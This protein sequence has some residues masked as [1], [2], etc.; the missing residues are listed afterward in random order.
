MKD[1]IEEAFRVAILTETSSYELY[2]NATVMIPD[3]RGKQVF[4]RLAREESKLIDEILKHCPD[5]L[6]E[7]RQKPDD[8]PLPRFDECLLE[9]P[10]RR[11]FNHLRVALRH[12]H[13]CIDRY[14]TFVNA[15]RDP[16]L[17]EVFE[18][19]L[20]MSRKQ[21]GLIAQEYTQADLRLHRPGVNRRAKRTH[22]RGVSRPAP[23]EHS[24][25]FISLLDSGR[26]SPF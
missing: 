22:F 5:R 18:L 12:K 2:R 15:F 3:G 23:N 16:A 9:S 4:E 17:C 24:Q 7:L 11:L 25:L 8:R 1:L 10:E 21:Y 13:A 6:A 14:A 26:R 20:G 19:A